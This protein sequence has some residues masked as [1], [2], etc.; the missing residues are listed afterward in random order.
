MTKFAGTLIALAAISLPL[1][2]AAAD[3]TSA[4]GAMSTA[5]K[6]AKASKAKAHKAMKATK[7]TAQVH[8]MGVI[9]GASN[10]TS[11]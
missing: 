4:S 9:R 2:A 5:A 10:D 3:A 1:G 6:P 7:S 8:T 11:K